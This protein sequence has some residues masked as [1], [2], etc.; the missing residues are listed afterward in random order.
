MVGLSRAGHE[1][2]KVCLLPP[3]IIHNPMGTV[4]PHCTAAM[5]NLM[6]SSAAASTMHALSCVKATMHSSC[7]YHATGRQQ[8]LPTSPSASASQVLV[9][10]ISTEFHGY[11]A[12]VT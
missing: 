12:L 11:V 5:E 3:G 2:E 6:T 1:H 4:G 7:R 10:P 9:A 8:E